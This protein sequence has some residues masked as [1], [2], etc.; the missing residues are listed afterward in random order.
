M[1]DGTERY[2]TADR[3][4]FRLKGRIGYGID[5]RDDIDKG[6]GIYERVKAICVMPWLLGRSTDQIQ[7]AA[8]RAIFPLKTRSRIS[9]YTR[10]YV[11]RKKIIRG[12]GVEVYNTKL[13][14]TDLPLSLN[15][16]G[17][18]SH[19]ERSSIS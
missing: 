3:K 16:V 9:L 7:Q 11:Q 12:S 1:Q 4:I 14:G 13:L 15:T 17:L 2:C 6:D 19:L 8:D 10:R 18:T 5:K